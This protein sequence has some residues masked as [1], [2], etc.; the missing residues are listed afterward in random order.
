MQHIVDAIQGKMI[1]GEPLNLSE[2]AVLHLHNETSRLNDKL[3]SVLSQQDTILT[4]QKVI[5]E[6]FQQG[7]GA[8]KLF[9]IAS[10][11]IAPIA[12]LAG[13][14]HLLFNRAGS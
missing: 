14:W 3:D 13:L 9:K 11:I 6:T 2:H 10:A 5:L 4:Q 8:L 1:R 7:S 12:A